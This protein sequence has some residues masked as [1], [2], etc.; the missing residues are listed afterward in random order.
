MTKFNSVKTKT[1]EAFES[2]KGDFKYTNAMQAPKITKVIISAGVG[3][4]KD[5]KR[6]D[7]QKSLD[8]NLFE[9]VQNFLLLPS[10]FARVIQWE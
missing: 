8:K 1:K 3:S 4:F 5:K 10:K 9:R 2:L 6:T 7:C